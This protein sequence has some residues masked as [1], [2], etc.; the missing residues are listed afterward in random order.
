MLGRFAGRCGS[1]GERT[2]QELDDAGCSV[3]IAG[4]LYYVG[5]QDL[6]SYLIATPKGHVLINSN[7][8]T[9]TPQIRAAIEKLGFHF[10][11][12]KTLLISQGHNDHCSGSARIKDL[13]H[14]QYM[15]M[16]GD[17]ATVESGGKLDFQYGNPAGNAIPRGQG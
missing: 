4:N 6:A 2:Q 7:L 17:V 5:S 1:A 13:T 15:V 9:S 11:D 8:V 14:A 16:D 10:G 12:V 3:P